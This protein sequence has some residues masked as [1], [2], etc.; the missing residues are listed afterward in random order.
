MSIFQRI[1]Q[2]HRHHDAIAFAADAAF[3]N[4][5]DPERLSNLSQTVHRSTSITHYAGATDHAQIFDFGQ[6]RQDVVLDAIGKKCVLLIGA[7][8]FEWKNRDTFCVHLRFDRTAQQ[9]IA[10]KKKTEP[11]S[12]D[13]NQG[14]ENER[15]PPL[16]PR[17]SRQ[18]GFGVAL[19][20]NF[21]R[22][23]RLAQIIGAKINNVNTGA[24]LDRYFSQIMQVR[25]PALVTLQILRDAFA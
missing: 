17:S 7:E 8:I 14:T 12:D 3:Q 24:M 18:D 16:S 23:L 22:N 19:P 4:V 21:C 15:I 2:L 11:N 25:S 13:R 5:G 10:Q 9:S 6:T 1:D 20:L